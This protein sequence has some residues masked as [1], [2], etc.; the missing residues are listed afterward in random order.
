MRVGSDPAPGTVPA[1]ASATSQVLAEPAAAL[2][3]PVAGGIDRRVESA[4]LRAEED[5][6]PRRLASGEGLEVGPLLLLS[7]LA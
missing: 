7:A 3:P 4:A 6:E 1:G 2:L 5:G